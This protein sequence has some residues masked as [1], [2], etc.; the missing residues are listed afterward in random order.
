M[1]DEITIAEVRVTCDAAPVQIEGRL[2]DGREFYFR[3]RHR[4]VSLSIDDETIAFEMRGFSSDAHPLS[5]IPE[6]DARNLLTVMVNKFLYCER[7]AS[8]P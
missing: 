4:M 8:L 7:W 1:D 2:S 6:A 5:F 3:S